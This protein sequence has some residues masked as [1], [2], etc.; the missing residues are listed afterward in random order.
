MGRAAA[1]IYSFDVTLAAIQSMA[2][3]FYREGLLEPIKLL[4]VLPEV[5]DGAK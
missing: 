5:L 2:Q 3:I 4:L 1:G